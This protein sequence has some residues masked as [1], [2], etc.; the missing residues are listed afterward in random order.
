LTELI[1]GE[2][3]AAVTKLVADLITSKTKIPKGDAQKTAQQAGVRAAHI[4]RQNHMPMPGS[5]TTTTTTTTTMTPA[6]PDEEHEG[7]D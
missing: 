5:M 3:A 2:I 6:K 7:S 4:V 1:I